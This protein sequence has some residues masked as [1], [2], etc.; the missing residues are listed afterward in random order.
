[1]YLE[2]GVK[3]CQNC[4]IPHSECGYEHVMSQIGGLLDLAKK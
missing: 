1:V 4:L 2:N 3:S